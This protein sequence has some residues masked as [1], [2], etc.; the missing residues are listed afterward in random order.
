M[1]L[2]CAVA[3]AQTEQPNPPSQFC[4]NR[5][6]TTVTA[7][8]STGGTG[9]SS[10]SANSTGPVKWNPGHYM[11]SD[12]IISAGDTIS[13]VQSEMDDIN[14]YD[15]I[16][17]YRV[18]ISWGALEPS[19]GVYNFAV[20]DAILTRLET[21]YNKPKRM[22]LVILPGQFGGSMP[23]SGSGYTIPSYLQTN[24]AYGASP[25]AG[26]YG[27][28]GQN[29]SGASTGPYA[30]ALWRPAVMDRMI[31]LVQALGAHYDN[32]PYF[33]A[34]M[35]QEDAWMMGLWLAAPDFSATAT[36]TQLERLLSA[37]T[38]AFPHTSVV[39]ENT[40]AGTTTSTE[41]FELWMVN[42]RIAPGTADT[43]GQTAFNMGYATSSLGLA[44][45]LQGYL[46][47]VPAG[48][49]YTGGDL[50][51]RS[52]A[53]LDVEGMDI[54][55]PYFT[56]WGARNGYEPLDIIDALNNTY[57][58]SHAFWTHFFGSEAE[59]GGTVKSESPWAVWSNL[60]P[61][62]NSNPLTHT[63]YPANY[64]QG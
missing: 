23:A 1:P 18:F 56:A 46:G 40:W 64:P 28:W 19:E 29:S 32:N 44:W 60:A 49:S 35:F 33:E 9:A 45:G 55:G 41:N 15:N 39:M 17:G 16:L 3:F 61:V 27:W 26:S 8:A 53:M 25:V 4:V 30:A 62:I 11:A 54:A 2:L 50:R 24:S 21:Q 36:V 7:S 12:T 20:L 57:Q 58:A 31:A 43:V 63:D 42:N 52:H 34:L 6:C 13:R 51:L 14:G 10:S 59:P 48:S 22:V 5:N 47:I 37:S 38:A